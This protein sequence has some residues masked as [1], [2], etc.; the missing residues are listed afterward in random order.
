M[1]GF[2]NEHNDFKVH[3][4]CNMY[5]HFIP[6]YGQTIFHCV[7]TPT[8][9]SSSDGY[10][11]VFHFLALVNFVYMSLCG[12]PFSLGWNCLS[13]GNSM[14]K[15]LR[16]YQTIFDNGYTAYTPRGT[17]YGLWFLCILSS[18]WYC[19]LFFLWP[20]WGV[21]WFGLQV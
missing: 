2:F 12:P 8:I 1:S 5:Q 15:L 19:L 21:V 10:S 7:D 13:S 3:P 18:T 4:C 11:G 20:S 17:I 16:S 6:F 9:H 14:L